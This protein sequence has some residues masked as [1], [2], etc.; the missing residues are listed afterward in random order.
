MSV[1]IDEGEPLHWIGGSETVFIDEPHLRLR[2]DTVP[3]S[4]EWGADGRVRMNIGSAELSIDQHTEGRGEIG[5]AMLDLS[6]AGLGGIMEPVGGWLGVD[7]PE[8]AGEM[9][10]ECVEN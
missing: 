2:G 5:N 7:G 3:A 8:F 9:P 4:D 6:V 10:M 1:T